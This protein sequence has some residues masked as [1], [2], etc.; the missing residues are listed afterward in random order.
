MRYSIAEL[1]WSQHCMKQ[2]KTKLKHSSD[3]LN[4]AEQPTGFSRGNSISISK[5]KIEELI[6]DAT[7]IINT[8][9]GAIIDFEM[10]DR[11]NNRTVGLIDELGYEVTFG[12]D[13]EANLYN[14]QNQEGQLP[15]NLRLVNAALDVCDDWNRRKITYSVDGRV[16]RGGRDIE[17]TYYNAEYACCATFTA[18]G[19]YKS[20]IISTETINSHYY[21]ST[22]GVIEI[23][24]DDGWVNM[25]QEW[26]GTDNCWEGV[27]T[28]LLQPGD[29]VI[30]R[31]GAGHILIYVATDEEGNPLYIDENSC[32]YRED[33]TPPWGPLRNYDDTIQQVW[34]APE[35]PISFQDDEQEETAQGNIK[36]GY[37]F[38]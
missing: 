7:K 11:E 6:E 20:G 35:Q 27:N 9:G 8:I 29:V 23:L 5:S 25:S 30:N 2:M 12:G 26:Y 21:H 4:I 1:C 17:N 31:G 15:K 22:D 13:F 14:S 28:D 32:V 3:S 33:G 37:E 34:R 36:N 10:A 24:A 19:I 16:D 18:A 38:D